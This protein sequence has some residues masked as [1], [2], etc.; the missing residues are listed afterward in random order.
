MKEVLELSVPYAVFEK[1][2]RAQ[3]VELAVGRSS[4]GLRDKNVAALRD[5]NSRVRLSAQQ[6]N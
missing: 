4:F 2:A 6:Q 1:L 5:L 3:F